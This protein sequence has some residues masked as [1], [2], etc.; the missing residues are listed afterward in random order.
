V[1]IETTVISAKGAMALV[2]AARDAAEA[3]GAHVSVAVCDPSG[4]LRAF[5]R[6]DGAPLG[7]V[8]VARSKA[9]S[10][11]T[12][13]TPTIAW[14]GILAQDPALREGLLHGV[15]GFTTLGGGVPLM[16]N[17]TLIGAIGISGVT[18]EKDHAAAEAAAAAVLG[19]S[20]P[21]VG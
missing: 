16:T 3:S 15:D 1:I 8:Q 7:T 4:V 18:A 2:V 11:A 20:T 14:H 13:A 12:F 17:G 9:L 6:M 21:S 19:S 10:A 5:L